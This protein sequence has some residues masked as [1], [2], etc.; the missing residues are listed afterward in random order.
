MG[1]SLLPLA[2]IGGLAQ[3]QVRAL[4]LPASSTPHTGPFLLLPVVLA[5][6]WSGTR[7]ARHIRQGNGQRRDILFML[8]VCWTPLAA[9]F[10]SLLLS[11]TGSPT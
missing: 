10:L 5:V 4:R 2:W 3:D 11:L 1:Y 6:G 7:A 8:V 9:W